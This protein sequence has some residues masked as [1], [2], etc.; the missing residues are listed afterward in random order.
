V[1]RFKG[2]KLD[3]LRRRSWLSNPFTATTIYTQLR[4]FEEAKEKKALGNRPPME[5]QGGRTRR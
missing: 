2:F 1:E 5:G 4:A 3:E